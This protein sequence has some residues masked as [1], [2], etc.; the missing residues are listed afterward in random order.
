VGQDPG[1]SIGYL[2]MPSNN[3]FVIQVRGTEEYARF[4]DSLVQAAGATSRSDLADR[5]LT[6]LARDLGMVPP[7]RVTPPGWSRRPRR[8]DGDEGR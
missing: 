3:D 1:A 5:A 6:R 7:A 2:T 4:L 8:R